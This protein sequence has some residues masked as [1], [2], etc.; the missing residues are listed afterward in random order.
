MALPS[1]ELLMT[2]L[3]TIRLE[4]KRIQRETGE[5]S[6]L[7]TPSQLRTHQPTVKTVLPVLSEEEYNWVDTREGILRED[8]S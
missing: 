4:E 7:E 1:R 6:E 8:L 2:L 5:V 3:W